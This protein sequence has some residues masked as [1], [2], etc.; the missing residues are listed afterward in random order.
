[1]ADTA[2]IVHVGENSPE[3]VAFKLMREIAMA[4]NKS[5]RGAVAGDKPNRNWILD[6]YAQCLSVVRNPGT[7]LTR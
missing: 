7:N 1:M 2:P 6:T 5:L 3:E 4:E